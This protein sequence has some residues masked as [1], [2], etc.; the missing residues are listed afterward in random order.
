M[1]S[2]FATRVGRSEAELEPFAAP[3]AAAAAAAVEQWPG[4][5]SPRFAEV[6]GERFA[7]AVQA[8]GAEG[9]A[10]WFAR[11]HP[12]DLWLASACA[13]GVPGAA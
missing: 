8:S 4:L 10:A 1:F 5:A 13:A 12:A 9:G 3:F 2:T 7:A 6:L 11:L